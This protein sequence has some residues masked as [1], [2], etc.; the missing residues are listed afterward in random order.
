MFNIMAAKTASNIPFLAR[1]RCFQKPKG[2]ISFK[3]PVYLLY[4]L[5]FEDL[6]L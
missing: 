5:T 2:G 6:E 3:V 4:I 1:C